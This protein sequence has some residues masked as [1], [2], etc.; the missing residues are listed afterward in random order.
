MSE[1]RSTATASLRSVGRGWWRRS[2]QSRWCRPVPCRPA[3]Y[4]K[5]TCCPRREVEEPRREV[6]PT[7]PGSP[8]RGNRCGAGCLTVLTAVDQ[9]RYGSPACST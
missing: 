1:I 4:S 2:P 6:A 5:L 7:R 8:S 9:G 3:M